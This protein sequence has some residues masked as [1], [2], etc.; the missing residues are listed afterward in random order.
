[1][2]Y[3]YDLVYHFNQIESTP[4]I[5]AK[6]RKLLNKYS[7]TFDLNGTF[8]TFIVSNYK[9]CEQ[10]KGAISMQ[11]I[12]EEFM[13]SPSFQDCNENIKSYSE[14]SLRRTL[15]RIAKSYINNTHIGKWKEK[16]RTGTFLKLQSSMNNS[17][18]VYIHTNEYVYGVIQG[19]TRKQDVDNDANQNMNDDNDAKM[20]ECDD[21]QDFTYYL[22]DED[23]EIIE[24]KMDDILATQLSYDPLPLGVPIYNDDETGLLISHLDQDM[25]PPSINDNILYDDDMQ[26]NDDDMQQNDI[27][28][29]QCV[30]KRR[31]SKQELIKQFEERSTKFK[32]NRRGSM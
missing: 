4:I 9:Q 24:W 28:E 16:M 17:N 19:I 8:K 18:D 15:S 5:C 30:K 29:I 20:E 1:M 3:F 11:E 27:P 10:G 26:Q 23:W 13:K 12:T 31:L 22:T 14:S 6:S 2:A 25:L 21:D 7:D 32:R